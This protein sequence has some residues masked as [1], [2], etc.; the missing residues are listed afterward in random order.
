MNKK[1]IARGLIKLANTLDN[2]NLIV[3]AN[4]VDRVAKKIVVSANPKYPSMNEDV[5]RRKM[6]TGDY[7]SDII[8]YKSLIYSTYYDKD[9]KYTKHGIEPYKTFAYN[10]KLRAIQ[11]LKETSAQEAKAFGNQANRIKYDFEDDI[12]DV[13]TMFDNKLSLSLNEYL[14]KYGITDYSGNLNQDIENLTQLNT[15]WYNFKQYLLG[16]LNKKDFD[17]Y[18]STQLSKTYNILKA[19]FE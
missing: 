12:Q 17:V 11:K 16:K 8:T 14:T 18:L 13:N 5:A 9:G 15:A 4:I 3:E 1:V 10:F 6:P 7:T 2:M 19:K